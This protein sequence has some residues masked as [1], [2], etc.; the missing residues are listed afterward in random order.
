QPRGILIGNVSIPPGDIHTLAAQGEISLPTPP[1]VDVDQDGNA[2]DLDV[3]KAGTSTR[4]PELVSGFH[5]V[6]VAPNNSATTSALTISLAGGTVGVAVSAGV[7]VIKTRTQAY[8]GA[9]A[10]VNQDISNAAA[11][12]SV[13]VSAGNDL[14]QLA[15]GASVAGG[16]VGVGPAVPV[17]GLA[18]PPP[19]LLGTGAGVQG[20]GDRLVPWD[21]PGGGGRMGV[22]GGG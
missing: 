20:P 9:N 8:V 17:A 19:G 12:Q 2:H 13:S 21:A 18:N 3:F 22:R 6:A 10:L 4:T 16:E 5:G 1:A 7:N 15:V 11:Q 14:H